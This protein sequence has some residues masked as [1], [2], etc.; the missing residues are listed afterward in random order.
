MTRQRFWKRKSSRRIILLVIG[1]LN[2]SAARGLAS[3]A[4]ND[5]EGSDRQSIGPR[6][7][8][9]TGS[10]ST[11]SG[12]RISTFPGTLTLRSPI[13]YSPTGIVLER[14]LLTSSPCHSCYHHNDKYRWQHLCDYVIWNNWSGTTFVY[15]WWTLSSHANIDYIYTVMYKPSEQSS[16]QTP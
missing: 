10:V 8:A 5:E 11:G 2:L 13:T 4:G 3:E 9:L 14:K 16:Q 15:H 1:S 7:L 12:Y 6:A